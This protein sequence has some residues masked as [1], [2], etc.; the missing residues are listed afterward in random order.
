VP[1]KSV[2]V[3]KKAKV[4]IEKNWEAPKKIIEGPIEHIEAPKKNERP[5]WPED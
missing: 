3:P 2:E 5:I 1:K 4:E